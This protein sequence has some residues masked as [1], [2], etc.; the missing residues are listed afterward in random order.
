MIISC[1]NSALK[2]HYLFWL[3]LV[4]VAAHGFSP[5][6]VNGGCSP[7]AGR[8]LSSQWLLLSW[9]KAQQLRPTGLVARAMWDLPGPGSESTSPALAGGFLTTRLPNGL[10]C[11]FIALFS[12]PQEFVEK[13]VVISIS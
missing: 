12:E 11:C 9:S 3:H 7:A 5:V 8:D 4:F 2:K 1:R 13:T 10:N 6:A